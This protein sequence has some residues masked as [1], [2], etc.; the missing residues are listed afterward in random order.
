MSKK[1]NHVNGRGLAG[2]HTTLTDASV[3]VV[4]TIRKAGF[5]EAKVVAGVMR[6]AKNGVFRLKIVDVDNGLKVTVRGNI[7]VQDLYIYVQP[8]IRKRLKRCLKGIQ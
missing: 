8:H 4:N 1:K 3:K 2:R 6:K 7:Y 5:R